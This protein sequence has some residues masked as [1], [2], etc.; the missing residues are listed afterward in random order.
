[1]T[2]SESWVAA[3]DEFEAR[4][5]LCE[6]VLELGTDASVPAG[7]EPPALAGPVPEPQRGRAHALLDRAAEIDR[8]LT[9][10]RDR[11]RADL[12]G[13]PRRPDT[14]PR[15]KARFETLA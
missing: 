7:F 12:A 5:E 2:A 3:L 14:T 9:A 10:E 6:A 11:I 15:G 8:R 4:L 13:R 1:M